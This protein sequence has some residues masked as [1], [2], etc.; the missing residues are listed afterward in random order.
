MTACFD[1]L[2]HGTDEPVITDPCTWKQFTLERCYFMGI[3][4]SLVTGSVSHLQ[5][6][7]GPQPFPP[8]ATDVIRIMP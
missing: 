7:I 5:S 1:M 8:P 4:R 6:L 2:Q 3:E